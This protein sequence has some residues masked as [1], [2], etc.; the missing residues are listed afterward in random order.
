MIYEYAFTDNTSHPPNRNNIMREYRGRR[1]K[2]RASDIAFPFLQTCKMV[3]LEAYRLPLML[4]PLLVYDF[5]VPTRPRLHKL[6]PWQF[7]LIQ[8]IDISLQ[9]NSLE[10]GELADYM[11]KW[12]AQDRHKAAYVAPRFYSGFNKIHGLRKEDLVQILNFGLLGAD[13]TGSVDPK[14]GDEVTL[15]NNPFGFYGT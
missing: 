7:A 13:D 14:D 6:A 12:K 9:Q 3:Y 2:P 8:G 10:H 1:N 5:Q 4:N 15:A 11:K